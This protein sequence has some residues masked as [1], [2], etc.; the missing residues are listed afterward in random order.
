MSQPSADPAFNQEDYGKF[1]NAFDSFDAD[2][3]G[4]VSVQ[5]LA[6]L[7]HAVGFAPR[8]D[9]VEDM[10]EDISAPTFEFKSF[11]YIISRHRRASNPKQ[12][13]IDAFRLWDRDGS[14]MLTTTKIRE[15]LSSLK[16]PFTP[17]EIGE[18]LGHPKNFVDAKTDSVYYEDF[19]N[20][21]F[22]V[23]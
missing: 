23:F 22:E 6:E 16:K 19:V 13:M 4:L 20:L 21:I 17:D 8:A 7:L 11:L 9:E 1:R 15:L 2:R 12:E 18:L 5:R 14:R 3:D 10:I